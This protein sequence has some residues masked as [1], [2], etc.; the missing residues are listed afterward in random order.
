MLW[1]SITSCKH[2]CEPC[3]WTT[4]IYVYFWW[5]VINPNLCSVICLTHSGRTFSEWHKFL[6]PVSCARHTDS[7]HWSNAHK[8]LQ[9]ARSCTLTQLNHQE[10]RLPGIKLPVAGDSPQSTK[11]INNLKL[12]LWAAVPSRLLLI[13]WSYLVFIQNFCIRSSRWGS[14]QQEI[15]LWEMLRNSHAKVCQLGKL[16]NLAC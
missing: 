4:E 11:A 12:Q 10:H 3:S 1:I 7:W 15:W 5:R 8:G 14:V 2:V 13:E 9:M 6:C 16:S